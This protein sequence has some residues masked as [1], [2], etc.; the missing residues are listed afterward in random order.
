M[1]RDQGSDSIFHP[2]LAGP[3]LWSQWE[4][5]E[6]GRVVVKLGFGS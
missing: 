4:A 5:G 1:P 2:R 3:I 6:M